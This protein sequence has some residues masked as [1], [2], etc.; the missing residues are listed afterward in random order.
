M[1][2]NS[3]TESGW[4]TPLNSEAVYD[5]ALV[6]QLQQWVSGITG[7][8]AASVIA[9]GPVKTSSAFT[10]VENGCA[11]AV[12]TLSSTGAPV[13]QNQ[14]EG[15]AE[16]WRYELIECDITFYGPEG[17]RYATRLRDGLTI[18]Q[19][20]DEL[21]RFDI[22]AEN[23]GDITSSFETTDNI[24]L[25]INQLRVRL[26]RKTVRLYGIKSLVETPFNLI[27]E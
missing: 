23:C 24:S 26:N 5:D 12:S 18:S 25:R 15:N 13:I 14:E 2:N 27:G 19:N 21:N 8:P 22:S 1:S 17:Q 16:L 6:E 7:L 20:I 10:A 4:L 9:A 3:T 11:I